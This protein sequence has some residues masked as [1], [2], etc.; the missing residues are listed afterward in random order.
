MLP[1]PPSSV[2]IVAAER[3]FDSDIGQF[4]HQGFGFGQMA[5]DID[6]RTLEKYQE[7]G[8]EIALGNAPGT[9]LM[10][11]AVATGD[12]DGD[13]AAGQRGAA[14]EVHDR[15]AHAGGIHD[16]GDGGFLNLGVMH[17]LTDAL[18]HSGVIE[19]E[20]E[21][22]QVTEGAAGLPDPFIGDKGRAHG[23]G[24]ELQDSDGGAVAHLTEIEANEALPMDDPGVIEER[25]EASL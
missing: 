19:A 25:S 2:G 17:E 1:F 21:T 3:H 22:L 6:F 20:G 13:E 23:G 11:L 14:Q 12:G 10:G 8:D 15:A 16:Q 7:S 9:C 24:G 18:H 5:A 4:F